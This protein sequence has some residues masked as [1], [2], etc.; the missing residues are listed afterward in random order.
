MIAWIVFW[1]CLLPAGAQ[2]G[3]LPL[4]WAASNEAGLEVV[5][6]LLG[7]YPDAAGKTD[8]VRGGVSW[9]QCAYERLTSVRRNECVHAWIG[10]FRASRISN[11]QH[12]YACIHIFIHACIHTDTY[13]H[14]HKHTHARTHTHAHTQPTRTHTHHTHHSSTLSLSNTHRHTHTHTHT[15]TYTHTRAHILIHAHTHTQTHTY[16]HTQIYTHACLCTSTQIPTLHTHTNTYMY[17]MRHVYIH[18]HTQNMHSCIHI[19]SSGA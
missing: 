19:Y 10:I 8:K 15:H 12:P 16:T 4:H 13:T 6:V 7:V 17:N 14:T 11:S 1:P 5:S 9:V 2:Q 3:R 18:I